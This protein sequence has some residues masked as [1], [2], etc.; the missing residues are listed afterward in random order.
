MSDSNYNEDCTYDANMYLNKNIGAED[1]LKRVVPDQEC[2][3]V[4][5]RTISHV[6][7][8]PHF[9]QEEVGAAN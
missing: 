9:D 1:D 5:G 2:P 4:L 7:G 3:Q 6:V 8:S